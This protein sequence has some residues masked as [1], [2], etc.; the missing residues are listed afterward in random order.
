M[1][2]DPTTI[3]ISATTWFDRVNGNT[4]HSAQ[5]HV[6]LSDDTFSTI[7]VPFQYGYGEQYVDSA[8]DSLDTAGII[9][10]ERYS[11]GMSEPLWRYCRDRGIHLAKSAVETTKRRCKDHGAGDE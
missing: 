11:N 8:A 1:T 2:T 6:T 10:R 5:V 4:Y 3:T 9:E 7:Y